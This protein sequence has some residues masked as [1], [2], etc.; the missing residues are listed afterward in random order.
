MLFLAATL[1]PDYLLYY[2][3]HRYAGQKGTAD[4]L[5]EAAELRLQ[6]NWTAFAGFCPESA[7]LGVLDLYAATLM[8]WNPDPDRFTT[9]HPALA[10]MARA[11]AAHPVAGPVWRRHGYCA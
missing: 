5:R 6:R 9:M 2:Y 11:V 4:P 3:P 7:S 1:Y 8:A 10:G